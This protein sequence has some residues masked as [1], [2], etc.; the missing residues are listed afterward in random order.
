MPYQDGQLES[1]HWDPKIEVNTDIDPGEIILNS[2]LNS[3]KKPDYLVIKKA[4]HEVKAMLNE[5]KI[6]LNSDFV[7]EYSHHYGIPN[8]RKTGAVIIE[9]VN[10]EYC[11]KLIVQLPGQYHPTHFHALKE[12]TF[13]VL[14]GTL[15]ADVDGHE[16][17]LLPGETLLIQ[18]GVWHSFWSDGGTIFEEVST[19]HHNGD[20]TYRDPTIN[21]ME[22]HERKSIVDHWGRD[23]LQHVRSE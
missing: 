12:E 8:F 23:Q 4:V 13:Q 20:S 22:R 19:T 17:I 3:P 15:H 6:A 1:G 21:A 9:C 5:A 16:H 14:Y 11:K 10:R 18:P 7:V 2:T